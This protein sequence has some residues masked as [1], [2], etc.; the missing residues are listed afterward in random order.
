MAG[1]SAAAAHGVATVGCWARQLAEGNEKTGLRGA[2]DW[3]RE[4]KLKRMGAA[5]AEDVPD[6]KRQR[7][8]DGWGTRI[9]RGGSQ[10]KFP[11]SD[12]QDG[13]DRSRPLSQ[14]GM[15]VHPNVECDGCGVH[16]IRGTR[17]QSKARLLRPLLR[18]GLQHGLWGAGA[19]SG[20]G[21]PHTDMLRGACLQT[22]HALAL[23]AQ[24]PRIGIPQV[25]ANYDLCESCHRKS[26]ADGANA[27]DYASVEAATPEGGPCSHCVLPRNAVRQLCSAPRLAQVSVARVAAAGARGG[28]C[29]RQQ[30]HPQT[31]HIGLAHASL[32]CSA[33]SHPHLAMPRK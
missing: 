28:A 31:G 20:A 29:P 25:L 16:P 15:R 19:C 3:A 9:Q 32:K 10:K 26:V 11:E 24:L 30:L 7:S 4:R 14:N 22:Q 21:R 23:P 13:K 6:G 17:F 27:A 8:S 12:E 1:G 33:G 2:A 18:A 5:G